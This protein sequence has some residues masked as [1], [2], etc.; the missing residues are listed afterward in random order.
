MPN[1]SISDTGQRD[2]DDIWDFY[3]EVESEA[4]ANRIVGRLYSNFQLLAEYPNMARPRSEY[5]PGAR[6]H[7][8]PATPYVVFYHS[9]D[10]G[11]EIV[12]VVH[13]RRDIGRLFQ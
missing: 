12:R 10:A 9:T 8:V 2:I 4:V 7:T 5:L 11:I 6:S 1:Y 13:G 3:A